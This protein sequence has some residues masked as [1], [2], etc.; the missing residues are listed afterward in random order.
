M[1]KKGLNLTK[2]AD[3][4]KFLK[5][6]GDIGDTGSRVAFV[7]KQGKVERQVSVSATNEPIHNVMVFTP[8]YRLEPETVKALMDLEWDGSLTLFLQRDNPSG[9]KRMDILH[10]YRRGREQF[11]KLGYDAMLVVESD[12][13]PPK[14]ALKRLAALNADCAYGVYRFRG[15]KVMNIFE[16]YP[17]FNGER[18]RNVG[19]S[20]TF[21]PWLVE[22]A[23]KVG[24]WPC[25]GGGVGILLI[26]RKVLENIDFRVKSGGGPDCDTYFTR[27]V[28]DK[29]Y[30]QVADFG[31]VCGHKDVDGKIYYP[32]GLE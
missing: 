2:P 21:K 6:A 25:S 19:E 24:R 18:P 17:N 22:R 28:Y 7:E 31:V 9:D 1:E 20:L 15:S 30:S 23:K 26:R 29:G 27:D 3:V 16:M 10:Q 32:E 14:D 8:V 13:I 11:L 5:A 12:I 4:E